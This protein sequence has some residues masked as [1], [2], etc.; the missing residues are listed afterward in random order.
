[1]DVDALRLQPFD[2]GV[3][4]ARIDRTH[5]LVDPRRH[6]FGAAHAL[7][8]STG[9]LAEKLRFARYVA[10][11]HRDTASIQGALVSGRRAGHAAAAMLRHR[12]R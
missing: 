2:A 1:M 12:P 6:P 11:D 7:S 5:L 8:R 3:R 10:G 9:S 4:V